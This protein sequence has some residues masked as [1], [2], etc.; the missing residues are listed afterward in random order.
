[1]KAFIAFA[2]GVAA[3]LI[4]LRTFRSYREV[5]A[6]IANNRRIGSQSKTDDVYNEDRYR[7]W[8]IGLALAGFALVALALK[9]GLSSSVPESPPA[10][11]GASTSSTATSQALNVPSDPTGTFTVISKSMDRGL[12]V[13]TT[14]RSGS[15][16]VTWSK[17][18]YDCGNGMVMYLGTG[19]SYAEMAASMPDPSMAPIVSGSIADYVGR[20][21]C[22]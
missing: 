22:R 13:I 1:M 12:A 16:G 9:W 3:L 14:K 18:A 4:A 15:S 11:A 5:K 7:D 6:R 21:A 19:G 17:R 10:H 20:E 8:S 2:I